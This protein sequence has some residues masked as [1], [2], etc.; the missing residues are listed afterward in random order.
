M[1]NL[2]IILLMVGTLGPIC[3]QVAPKAVVV[4]IG[5]KEVKCNSFNNFTCLGFSWWRG[6]DYTGLFEGAKKDVR[7]NYPSS[8]TIVTK[9]GYGNYLIVISSDVKNET[10][11]RTFIGVGIGVDANEALK[12]AKNDMPYMWDENKYGYRTI[13]DR[14][15]Q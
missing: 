4:A 3:A 12:K 7:E 2:L 13:V 11:N 6:S 9:S 10:C 15:V 8:E 5:Q 1:K 14:S